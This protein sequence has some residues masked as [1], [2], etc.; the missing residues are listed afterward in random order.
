MLLEHQA[1]RLEVE[2]P[3]AIEHGEISRRAYPGFVQLAAFDVE[4]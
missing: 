2:F 3:R 4:F 1:H